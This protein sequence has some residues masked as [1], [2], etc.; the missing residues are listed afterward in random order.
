MNHSELE[1]KLSYEDI[2]KILEIK[3]AKAEAKEREADRICI[4]MTKLLGREHAATQAAEDASC[5]LSRIERKLRSACKEVSK[6]VYSHHVIEESSKER[7]RFWVYKTRI[8]DLES[9]DGDSSYKSSCD[10]PRTEPIDGPMTR[11]DAQNLAI[12]L[13]A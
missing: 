10:E 8:E 2:L 4:D 11:I 5:D 6:L 9:A 3:R 7:K 1:Q 12:K 13:N